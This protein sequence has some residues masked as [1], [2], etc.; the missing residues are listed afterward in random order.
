LQEASVDWGEVAK[1]HGIGRKDNATTSFKTMMK[2]YGL[3]FAN[4][5]FTVVEGIH[6][7]NLGTTPT[8]P[9]TT[10]PKTPR[11]RKAK[12]EAETNGEDGEV[13]PTKKAKAVPKAEAGAAK[14]IG[15]KDEGEIGSV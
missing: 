10:K 15:V 3:E 11:K 6:S 5:K 14:A 12:E 13:S 8:K 9:K 7:S 2:K 4:K 1:D